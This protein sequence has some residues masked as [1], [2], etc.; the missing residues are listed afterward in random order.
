MDTDTQNDASHF[1]TEDLNLIEYLVKQALEHG[2]KMGQTRTEQ[3]EQILNKLPF[4]RAVAW[5]ISRR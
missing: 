3:Y 4:Y 2:S 5:Q 1:T